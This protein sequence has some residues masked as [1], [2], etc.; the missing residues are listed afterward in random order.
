MNID[1]IL[2]KLLTRVLQNFAGNSRMR[3]KVQHALARRDHMIGRLTR[4]ERTGF[5]LCATVQRDTSFETIRSC[6]RSRDLTRT[7]VSVDVSPWEFHC[8]VF[9]AYAIRRGL[10]GSVSCS[11]PGTARRVH[12]LVCVYVCVCEW[13]SLKIW[14]ARVRRLVAA[15]AR[16]CWKEKRGVV[17]A[18][19]DSFLPPKKEFHA[20]VG[21]W[22]L[23]LPIVI[24]VGNTG[25]NSLAECGTRWVSC[26][27]GFAYSTRDGLRE[28]ALS[29]LFPILLICSHE[30]AV[31][32]SRGN[33]RFGFLFPSK[34][35]R[36]DA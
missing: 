22:F 34:L 26:P 23:P 17:A 29:L 27:P 14:K 32:L 5:S 20:T 10:C 3:T 33:A 1:F 28:L 21:R 2:Y 25:S 6:A 4:T 16:C 15:G 18:D 35:P 13:V 9:V 11:I 24:V 36:I 8:R 19:S 12:T 30:V 7:S 31:S